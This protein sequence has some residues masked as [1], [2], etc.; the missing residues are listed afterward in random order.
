M[1]TPLRS[2]L[3][4]RIQ[5]KNQAR[6]SAGKFAKINTLP[7]KIADIINWFFAPSFRLK[8]LK[9]VDKKSTR[10]SRRKKP[11]NERGFLGKCLAV[12]NGDYA[13]YRR[14]QARKNSRILYPVNLAKGEQ[15]EVHDLEKIWKFMEHQLK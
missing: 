2:K 9:K 10:K 1:K 6:D 13:R 4:L 15:K 12:I 14:R 5:A 11:I 8:R 7:G 3:S